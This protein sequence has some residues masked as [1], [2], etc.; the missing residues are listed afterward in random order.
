[1]ATPTP[2]SETATTNGTGGEVEFLEMASNVE[3]KLFRV[4]LE[5]AP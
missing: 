3:P 5:L 2:W 4:S 1:L